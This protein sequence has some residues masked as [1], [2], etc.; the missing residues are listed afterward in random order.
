MAAELAPLNRKGRGT[1]CFRAVSMFRWSRKG[2]HGEVIHASGRISGVPA[3]HAGNDLHGHSERIP[4]KVEVTP[5]ARSVQTQKKIPLEWAIL[6]PTS[7]APLMW[8][9]RATKENQQSA[10]SIRRSAKARKP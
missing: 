1:R 10:L 5:S 8:R 4:E 6:P 3:D 2:R 7:P 9:T